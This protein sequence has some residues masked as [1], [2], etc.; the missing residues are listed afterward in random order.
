MNISSTKVFWFIILFSW[1]C[2]PELLR[3]I[4]QDEKLPDIFSMSLEE[5]I[6]IKVVTD[7]WWRAYFETTFTY[8]ADLLFGVG[9]Q[10]NKPENVDPTFIG[11]LALI[12]Q[13]NGKSGF[14]FLYGAAFR[15]A[16]ELENALNAPGVLTG[17]PQLKPEMISTFDLQYF[18]KHK[19]YGLDITYFHSTQTN[20]ITRVVVAGSTENTYQN[21][22]EL[23]LQGM[24]LEMS[25]SVRPDLQIFMAHTQQKNERGEG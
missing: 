23:K 2:L 20:L 21:I 4:P 13:L 16:F 3:A 8:S 5:L 7:R 14:K 22:G 12:K 1:I 18:Y 19:N 15:S 6:K 10:F 17:N 24:E 11:R 25:W 9:G